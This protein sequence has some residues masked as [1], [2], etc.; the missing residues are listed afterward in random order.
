MGRRPRSRSTNRVTVIG[1]SSECDITLAD[2]NVSRRHAEVRRI[3]DGYSLVDLGSTNGTEVNGQRIQETALMNGDVISVRHHLD[4]VR[5][6][7]WLT[8]C[9]SSSRS[10]FVVLLYLFI[11]RVIRVASRDVA[12]GQESMV[13]TPVRPRRREPRPDGRLVV[14]QS[15]ELAAGTTA[16]RSTASCVR[17]RTEAAQIPLGRGRICFR[18]PCPVPP[19]PGARHRRGS[20]LDQRD[21][22]ERRAAARDARR[23]PRATWSRSAR[24]SSTLRG[25]RRDAARRRRQRRPDPD[26][27]RAPAT[28][29][30]R[31]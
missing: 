28:T 23:W 27:P 8:S 22:R 7:P 6:A 26:R 14:A 25:G 9:C 21:V 13:L 17:G 1:R 19:R 4:H 18:P 30:T 12:V 16:S 29:R 3:G 10:A 2:P 31:T 20:G 5:A 11:W 15:P 24:R